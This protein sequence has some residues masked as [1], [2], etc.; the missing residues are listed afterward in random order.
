M[1]TVQEV[2]YDHIHRM[3][4]VRDRG[5]ILIHAAP[6]DDVLIASVAIYP[7]MRVAFAPERVLYRF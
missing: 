6:H 7:F 2:I 4:K 1:I 3:L 5:Q